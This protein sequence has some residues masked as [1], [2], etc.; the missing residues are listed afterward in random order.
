M[1]RGL[2]I[3]AAVTAFGWAALADVASAVKPGT[4]CPASFQPAPRMAISPSGPRAESD[5]D[6]DGMVCVKV[7]PNGRPNAHDDGLVLA[8]G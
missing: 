6:G 5:R 2:A 8:T 3:C 7:G 1:K 4:A